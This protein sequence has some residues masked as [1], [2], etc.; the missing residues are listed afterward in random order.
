[1]RFNILN[2]F[3]R[4]PTFR[5]EHAKAIIFNEFSN[6]NYWGAQTTPYAKPFVL[7]YM[8]FYILKVR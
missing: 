2:S 7:L 5:Q 8:H 3:E 4:P 1:M 6:N